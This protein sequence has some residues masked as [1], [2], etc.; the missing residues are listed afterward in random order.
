MT[1]K[2]SSSVEADYLLVTASG[3]VSNLDDMTEL[4]M[5]IY[6]EIVSSTKQKV[7]VDQR[8]YVPP[9]TLVWQADL[10]KYYSKDFPIELRQLKIAIVTAI[11]NR[12][13]A[14]FFETYAVNRGYNV[15]VFYSMDEAQEYI[16]E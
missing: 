16:Q 14:D 11:E 7:L 1:I 10:V 6:Q 2:I 15:K 12:S 13:T 4:T 5:Q 3:N 9:D 8:E